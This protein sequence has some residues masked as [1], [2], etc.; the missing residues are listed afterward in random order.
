[1][2]SAVQNQEVSGESGRG[3]QPFTFKS[4]SNIHTSQVV[5]SKSI[6]KS[7]CISIVSLGILEI[8]DLWS[9]MPLLEVRVQKRAACTTLFVVLLNVKMTKGMGKKEKQVLVLRGAVRGRVLAACP[10]A[11][12]VGCVNDKGK[13]SKRKGNRKSKCVSFERRVCS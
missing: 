5:V 13:E 6:K 11:C 4:P 1:M 9:R 2:H 12:A 10:R 7:N 8:S 3:G